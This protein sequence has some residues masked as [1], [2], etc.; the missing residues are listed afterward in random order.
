MKR[1]GVGLLAILFSFSAYAAKNS[2]TVVLTEPVNVGSV[3]L[4]AGPLKVTWTGTGSNA[5]LT[6]APKQKGKAP[7]TVPAQVLDQKHPENSIST[8][9][10]NGTEVLQEVQLS[11]VTLVLSNAST[12]A[13][14]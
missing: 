11:D 6:L 3:Q 7:I 13:G 12:A 1:F 4:P 5:Q 9:T 8:A 10:I 14:N 2:Q